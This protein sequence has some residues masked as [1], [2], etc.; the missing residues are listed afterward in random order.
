MHHGVTHKLTP[1]FVYSTKT[2]FHG[3]VYE[4]ANENMF[5][6]ESLRERRK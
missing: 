6:D 1:N 3:K 2:S 5:N 4:Q